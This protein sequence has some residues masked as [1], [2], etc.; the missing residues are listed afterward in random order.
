[1]RSTLRISSDEV[2]TRMRRKREDGQSVNSM[3]GSAGRDSADRKTSVKIFAAITMAII[4]IALLAGN[5]NLFWISIKPGYDV[6]Y[7]LDNG[8]REGMHVSGKVPYTYDCFANMGD[9]D[10]TRVSAYYYAL[11]AAE[12]MMILNIPPQKQKDME[13]LLEETYAYLDGG[14]WPVSQVPVEGYV[15]KAQGRLPYLLSRYMLEIG[16]TQEEI[17][18]IGQPLMIQYDAEKMQKARIYAPVAV[19]LLALEVLLIVIP[20]VVRK[21]R[22]S[23]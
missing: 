18:A 20:I 13:K 8:A 12:G 14:S 23:D 7:L 6:E 10:D 3:F 15:T 22:G 17:D 2:K 9:F 1:M 19:I 11:P 21:L 16:Y 4:G 5:W